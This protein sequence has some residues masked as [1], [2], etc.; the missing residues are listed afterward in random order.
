VG[1]DNKSDNAIKQASKRVARDEPH[2]TSAEHIRV[3]ATFEVQI[4]WH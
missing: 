4:N 1:D 3:V 2:R